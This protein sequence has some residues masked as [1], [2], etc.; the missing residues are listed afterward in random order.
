MRSSNTLWHAVLRPLSG[1][2]RDHTFENQ[3]FRASGLSLIAAA[4]VY[5]NTVYLHRAVRHAHALGATIPNNLR[6]YAA[7]PG[8]E[9]IA[10]TGNCVWASNNAATDFR[11]LRNI[12]SASMSCAA[13]QTICK[14]CAVTSHE[15]RQVIG[16][17][18]SL[19]M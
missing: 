2:I 15:P 9:P 11:R 16:D 18:P 5:W 19:N 4:I 6:A 17:T 12:P 10:L 14:N 13:C 1:E 3:G 8:R 7:P